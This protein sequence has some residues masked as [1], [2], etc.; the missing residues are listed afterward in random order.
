MALETC[1]RALLATPDD[2]NRW[3]DVIQFAS[4]ISQPPRG[5]KRHNL[6]TQIVS[7][8]DRATRS[9]CT[10]PGNLSS[11]ADN[12]APPAPQKK[13]RGGPGGMDMD[14]AAVHRASAKLQEGD[15]R[16]AVRC[17]CSEETLAP[18]TA[19]TLESLIAKHPSCPNDRR[20]IP[21]TTSQPL[22]V[23]AADVK[24]AIRSFGPG[25]AGGR[26]GLRP[27]HLKD[28]TENRIGGALAEVLAEFSNLVLSGGVPEAVRPV[29]F[30]ATLLPFI[31]KDGGIRPIAVGLTLRRLVSKIANSSAI[32]SCTTTLAPT[33]L[34]VGVKGGAEA[35][36]HSARLYLQR[37]DETRAFCQAGF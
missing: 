2:L 20:A 5:G 22:T 14:E 26:D 35:L 27:Q 24:K 23:S 9:R 8:I 32:E 29:F 1:L 4:C 19:A 36:I 21:T 3:R 25:S 28:M 33:Q 11:T 37:M 16:G 18:S 6:T 10:N 31:K 17:L 30:G 12:R 34:G 13:A 7:Q 15:I